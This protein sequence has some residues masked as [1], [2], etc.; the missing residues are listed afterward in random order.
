MSNSPG[1]TI[2]I[3]SSSATNEVVLATPQDNFENVFFTF[4]NLSEVS[5]TIFED[6]DKFMSDMG[7]L[8][9]VS[10]A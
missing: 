10:I 2:P 3:I 4:S 1:V 6:F 7:T 9:Y 8:S 5:M